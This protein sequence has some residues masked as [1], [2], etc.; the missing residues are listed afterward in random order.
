MSSQFPV[1]INRLE[2]TYAL[3]HPDKLKGYDFSTQRKK[4]IPA[5]A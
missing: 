4:G 3:A 2:F 5:D 1:W